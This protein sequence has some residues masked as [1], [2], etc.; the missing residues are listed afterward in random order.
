M[1][2]K[3][4]GTGIQHFYILDKVDGDLQPAVRD[5][6]VGS[7]DLH[8]FEGDFSCCRLKHKDCDTCDKEVLMLPFLGLYSL[9]LRQNTPFSSMLLRQF[10]EAED[11]WFPRTVHFSRVT[12][13]PG[14][15]G[16]ERELFGDLRSEIEKVVLAR[17]QA[18]P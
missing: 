10:A 3:M 8:I 17:A 15:L 18:P 16:E 1:L 2:G 6:I 7:G 13:E 11:Q 14:S 12:D 4:C 9:M 5:Q